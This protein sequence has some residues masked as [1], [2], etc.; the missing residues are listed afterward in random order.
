M[1]GTP[2]PIFPQQF[3]TAPVV[4]Q[5]APADTTVEKDVYT[6][7][8]IGAKIESIIVTSTDSAAR[9]LVLYIKSTTDVIL[10]TISIPANSGNTNALPAINVLASPQFALNADANGNKF[11][12]LAAGAKL[13]AAMGTTITAAK[14]VNLLLQGAEF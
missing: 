8:S 5:F 3:L 2:T 11:L 13:R 4:I 7:G 10:G 9:D 1:Q 14:V 6:A 12:Y